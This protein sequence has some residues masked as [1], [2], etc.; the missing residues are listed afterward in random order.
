MTFGP[1][2]K[3]P[4]WWPRRGRGPK[5]SK[6]VFP[7]PPHFSSLSWG[8]LRGILVVFLKRRGPEMCTHRLVLGVVWSVRRE[9]SIEVLCC[10]QALLLGA[11]PF[12]ARF[13]L[14]LGPTLWGHD[15]HQIQKWIGQK[16]IGAIWIGQIW[17]NQDGPNGIGQSQS[18]PRGAGE[19]R[20]GGKQQDD[21]P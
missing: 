5:I 12:G 7:L 1:S 19:G 6:F 13:F 21:N 16:W 17:S 11:P 8:S 2:S 15:T 20:R 4:G 18:L 10:P 9:N 14:G 3:R